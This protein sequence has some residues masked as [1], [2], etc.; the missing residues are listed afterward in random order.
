[1]FA[2]LDPGTGSLVIQA[3]IAAMVGCG[4]Y[5]NRFLVS[6]VVWLGNRVTGRKPATSDPKNSSDT[7]PVNS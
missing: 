2:Y 6:P 5:F 3:V 4:F 1:M 7:A